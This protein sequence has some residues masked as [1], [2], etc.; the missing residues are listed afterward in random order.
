MSFEQDLYWHNMPSK[1]FPSRLINF[2]YLI[3]TP[4]FK[5]FSNPFLLYTGTNELNFR[6]FKRDTKNISKLRKKS[7]HIFL[8]EPVSYY[9]TTEKDYSLG[10]YSEF[11]NKHNNSGNI[12]AAELDSIQE[13]SKEFGVRFTVNTCDYGLNTILGHLY[14][15]MNIVCRDIFLRQAS[16]TIISTLDVTKK[17]ISKKFWCGNGR[18]T[19]HRHMIM[20][21]LVNKSGNYSWRFKSGID[22]SDW[23]DWIE[24]MPLSILSPNAHFL[25]EKDYYLDFETEK[26]DVFGKDGHYLPAGPFSHPSMHYYKT[27]RECFLAVVNETRFAQPT[28]N[29]SEKVIDAINYGSPFLLVAPPRT[30]E[31]L[32][33]FGFK[34]FSGYWDEGYDLEENHS[35]RMKMIFKIIDYINSLSLKELTAMHSSMLSI[36]KHNRKIL[37]QLHINSE[38]I[39]V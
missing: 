38:I 4:F 30:L 10:Y 15:E 5:R 24:D 21:Y 26:V 17:D 18:Y 6:D 22:W 13:F 1:R 11:H 2:N 9:L 29:F 23:V 34:T 12:R 31:Y 27:F 39:H 36:L 20:C 8:Y 16:R 33:T 25:N 7:P 19:I 14:P 28:A 32:K 37:S 35:K 3:K